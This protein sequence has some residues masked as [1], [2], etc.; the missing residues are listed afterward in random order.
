MRGCNFQGEV[1]YKRCAG[2]LDLLD[3]NVKAPCISRSTF[4][5]QQKD[6]LKATRGDYSLS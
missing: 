6:N 1:D 5:M 3:S 2:A 4:L